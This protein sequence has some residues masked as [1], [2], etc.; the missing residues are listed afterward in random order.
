MITS[1]V[2][3]TTYTRKNRRDLLRLVQDG[4]R[5]HIHLE[6]H[7]VD[8]WIDASEGPIHLAWMGRSLVG[9]I[10]SSA[11]LGDT[12]WLRLVAIDDD[13]D[14]DSLLVEL[15]ESLRAQL[16]ERDVKQVGVLLMYPWLAPH[17]E[18][19]GF[20]LYERIVTLRRQGL[21]VPAPLRNDVQIRNANWRQ[22]PE[23]ADID[24]AAFKP[25]WQL[26]HAVLREAA[27]SAASFTVAEIDGRMVGYELST[28]YRDGAHLARLATL[29]EVQG[30]GVGGILLGEMINRFLRRGV[31]SVSVNTQATN[32]QS[33]RLYQ[34]YGFDFTG[35]DMP[36]W[37]VAI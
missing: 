31:M 19:L 34:R 17:L 33:Q 26:H 15:W 27:R 20:V 32:L 24:H 5:L 37:T 28:L 29:P 9:A 25:L 23:V 16:V 11:P 30:S 3:L 1:P 21:N 2:T 14:P 22:A 8:E 10:A 18:K 36:V 4:Q 13:V 6:W 7:T 12:A 35:L